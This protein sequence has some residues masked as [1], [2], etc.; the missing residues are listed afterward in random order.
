MSQALGFSPP[1]MGQCPLKGL[2]KL[3]EARACLLL[4]LQ[5]ET[6]PQDAHV[7]STQTPVRGE[8]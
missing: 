7:L 3:T 5:Y 8:A 6:F 2:G 1:R 4:W